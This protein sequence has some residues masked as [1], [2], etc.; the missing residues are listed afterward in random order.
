VTLGEKE[1]WNVSQTEKKPSRELVDGVGQFISAV[2]LDY[3]ISFLIIADFETTALIVHH[4]V[5]Y[6]RKVPEGVGF[7]SRRFWGRR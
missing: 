6:W 5:F 7:A 3:V 2:G 1:A 4:K